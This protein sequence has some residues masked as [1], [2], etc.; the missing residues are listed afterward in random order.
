[1]FFEADYFVDRNVLVAL[2]PLTLAVA[3]GLGAGRESWRASWRT[4]WI[5][6]AAIMCAVV[7]SLVLIVAVATDPHRQRTDWR[8]IAHV[9][10][11][12]PG[13]RV[14]VMNNHPVLGWA[15]PR[16][17]RDARE[18]APDDVVVVREVDVINN[19]VPSGRCDVFYGRPCTMHPLGEELPF[20]IATHFVLAEQPRVQDFR[21]DRYDAGVPV[22][23]R[24]GSLVD[25]AQ[26]SQSLMV[27]V[28][29]H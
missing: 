6:A 16:Y 7:L 4:A 23:V 8:S 19:V 25:P 21:I 26:L 9:V 14:V 1:V 18:L 12:Q 27:F 10:Q 24:A 17:L 22:P 3:I 20:E 28:P 2:V 5:G 15:M 13:D 11:R 29:A